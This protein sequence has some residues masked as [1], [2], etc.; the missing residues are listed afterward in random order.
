[1]TSTSAKVNSARN[2]RARLLLPGLG[3]VAAAT[4]VSYFLSN[5][6]TVVSAL[7]I[8]IVLGA[9]VRN[10]NLLPAAWRPGIAWSTK[11]S[12]RAGV[13]LLGLQLSIP[14]VLEL[15][16]GEI[17]V[18]IITVAVTFAATL[19]VG[20]LIGTS[21]TM[22]LLVATGFS[23]CGASAIAAMSA[24]VDDGADS[25]E[26]DDD[27][28]TAIALVTLF[29]SILI[30]VLPALKGVT[31]FDDHQMG[32]WIG[33]S[34]QEV[35]QVVAAAAAVSAACVTI[36][37]VTK[38]GRVVLLAPMVAIVGASRRRAKASTADAQAA[39]EGASRPPI[40]PLFVLGFLACVVVRS[41]V[42]LPDGVF[43]VAKTLTTLLLTAAMFCLGT[44]VHFVTLARTGWRAALLGAISTAIAV[45]VSWLGVTLVG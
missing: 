44:G 19:A 2:L 30:F 39:Q 5:A 33:A 14:Q 27:I 26:N 9:V 8:A 7:I 18:V 45:T 13:V 32:V 21:R 29:G 3:V 34:V 11:K 28:A 37:T 20:R 24:V 25:S 43:S 17:V 35:A 10:A 1:M 15:G 38:L 4:A 36:A 6:L 40:V 42:P 31:G 12:L 22:S 41:W 16:V 23:I